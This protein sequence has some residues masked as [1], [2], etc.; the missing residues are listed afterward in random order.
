[1]LLIAN[2]HSIAGYAN[3]KPFAPGLRAAA[4]LRVLLGAQCWT[5]A[6]PEGFLS[7]GWHEKFVHIFPL[8][9]TAI[10]VGCA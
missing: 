4:A 2:T 3:G 8:K 1:M 10:S 7:S 6:A 5:N 9:K